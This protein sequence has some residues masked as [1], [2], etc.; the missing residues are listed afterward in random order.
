MR[1][2]LFPIVLALAL[3]LAA[4]QP[5]P[6]QEAVPEGPSQAEIEAAVGQVRDA[7]VTAENSGDS[8]ALTAPFTGDG[9][10]MPAN[11]PGEL[12][13]LQDLAGKDANGQGHK[14]GERLP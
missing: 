3:T 12:V 4:C 5:A 11:A 1:S 10:L 9:V 13:A 6:Q 8:A 7:Y 14:P 2:Y